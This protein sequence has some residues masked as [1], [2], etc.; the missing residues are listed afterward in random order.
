MDKSDNNPIVMLNL[1]W[2]NPLSLLLLLLTEAFASHH[3]IIIM[4]PLYT[5]FIHI[6][7]LEGR[8]VNF[9]MELL[10]LQ[11]KGFSTTTTVLIQTLEPSYPY[12]CYHVGLL[13]SFHARYICLTLFGNG[14]IIALVAIN[15]SYLSKHDL[16]TESENKKREKS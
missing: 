16:N 7:G 8:L 4:C 5:P 15:S 12:I 14:L 2:E 1:P 13:I 11:Q 6:K 3:I 9:P 10:L